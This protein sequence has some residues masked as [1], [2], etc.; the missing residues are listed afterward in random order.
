MTAAAALAER[1]FSV[2]PL[3]PRQKRPAKPDHQA[4]K[5]SGT[6][7]RCRSGHTGW[8]PRATTDPGRIRR[9]WE[10]TPYNVGVACGPS[11]LV[12]VDL[13]VPK[14]EDGKDIP[15]DWKDLGGIETGA[16][17][18]AWICDAA[19]MDWPVTFTVA[20]PSG[21]WH[22]YF[23]APD[24][25]EFHNSASLIGPLIDTRARGGYVVG[26]GSITAAGEYTVLHDDPIVPLPRWIGRLLTPPEP[27][28]NPR[29]SAS[30]TASPDKRIAG[31]VRT[32]ESARVGT[33]N[34]ILFWAACTLAE[35]NVAELGQLA[36]A[37][38]RAGLDAG[39]IDG[40][41]ASAVRRV[42]A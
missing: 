18:F 3:V 13:D 1:G 27:E 2:F 8:E 6:D 7:P 39:E 37:A 41:I 35:F 23:Q 28:G 10:R 25:D 22:L 26:A 38:A 34:D 36:D 19:G 42:A 20:T 9:G 11:R 15:Q 40:T 30:F 33:R 29:G 24:D 5:C 17:V 32:V 31:L 21:G 4:R 14:P 12:V 16:D